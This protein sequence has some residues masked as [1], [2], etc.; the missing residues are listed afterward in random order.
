M[1]AR[2][3]VLAATLIAA[4]V[5]RAGQ[6]P[7]LEFVQLAADCSIA[8]TGTAGAGVVFRGSGRQAGL[9]F[10]NV[11]L[12]TFQARYSRCSLAGMMDS[13]ERGSL[14]AF[15]YRDEARREISFTGDT[16]CSWVCERATP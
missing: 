13:G 9:C 3:W 10:A 6:P 11:P 14:C 12:E 15:D 1:N 4:G 2:A 7:V 8:V 5:A 16:F